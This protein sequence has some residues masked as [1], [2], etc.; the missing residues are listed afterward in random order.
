MK[1]TIYIML[2]R[3]VVIGTIICLLGSCG[4]GGGESDSSEVGDA[5]FCIIWPLGCLDGKPQN[6]AALTGTEYY[7]V[8]GTV[9]GLSGAGLVLQINSGDD[10]A[11]A[12]NGEFAFAAALADGAG[13]SIMVKTQPD[14]QLCLVS[15]GTGTVENGPVRNVTISCSPGT[16]ETNIGYGY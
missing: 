3:T 4:G 9:T 16:V 6:S 7:A 2:R 11:L 8:G 15:N 13:Y 12:S 1:H 14:G 10:L 5:L